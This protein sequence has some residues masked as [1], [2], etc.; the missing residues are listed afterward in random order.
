M[1]KKVVTSKES[2]FEDPRVFRNYNDAEKYVKM[3]KS[4]GGSPGRITAYWV[5]DANM[6]RIDKAGRR[7]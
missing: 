3:A 2:D 7:I 5:S 6:N 1:G 4:G